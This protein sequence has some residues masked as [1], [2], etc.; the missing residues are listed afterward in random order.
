[1]TNVVVGWFGESFE[2]LDPLL[3]NLH[4]HGSGPYRGG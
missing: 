4:R 2:Q 3:Q 1:M